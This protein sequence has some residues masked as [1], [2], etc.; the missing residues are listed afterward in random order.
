ME[1]LRVVGIGPGHR[2]YILP[3]AYKAVEDSDVL[4]GGRRN[5]E[6][7]SDFKGETLSIT[8]DLK[9][10][11]EYI[12]KNRHDKK[13]AI[14]LSGDTGFYSMLNYLSNYFTKDE[15]E[16]IPGITSLQYLYGKI[17]ETW[18]GSP[19][20]SLHGRE[21]DFIEKLKKHKKV[22][23]LTDTINTPEEIARTLINSHLENVTMIVGENLS[24]PEERIIEGRPEEII[25]KGPYKMTVVVIK[26][27]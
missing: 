20:M 3:A 8:R 18:Q 21:E 22:G 15:M 6:T 2:D 10:V 16:V 9:S 17:K 7:F 12:K 27:E 5:L 26:H 11:I 24:Y 13:I 4:I 14:I 23:L 1:K 25:K 19:L